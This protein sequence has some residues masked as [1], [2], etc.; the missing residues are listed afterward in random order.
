MYSEKKH[1]ETLK[2]GLTTA[3]ER[4]RQKGERWTTPWYL[5][6]LLAGWSV[7]QS[8]GPQF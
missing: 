1:D 6:G 2:T 7:S 8:V 5:Y 4:K 3:Q